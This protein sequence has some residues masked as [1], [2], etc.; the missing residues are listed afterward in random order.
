MEHTNSCI[1]F[2]LHCKKSPHSRFWVSSISV[3]IRQYHL[4]EHETFVL[5]GTRLIVY[6]RLS[7]HFYG[8]PKIDNCVYQHGEQMPPCFGFTKSGCIPT[9]FIILSKKMEIAFLLF[10]KFRLSTAFS[11]C[12]FCIWKLV[13]EFL[14][15]HQA[16]GK[17]W[18]L[19]DIS[20]GTHYTASVATFF[21][22]SI[23]SSIY[24]PSFSSYLPWNT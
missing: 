23:F 12:L 22:C 1:S 8:R 2:F 18:G 9:A 24:F 7:L 13:S 19:L 3:I 21:I 5:V 17:A 4:A 6:L 15:N 11:F 16:S 10:V 14:R 20:P